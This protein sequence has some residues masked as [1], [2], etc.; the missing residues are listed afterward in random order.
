L[1][2]MEHF[3][4]LK[5][6]TCNLKPILKPKTHNLKPAFTLIEIMVVMAIMA[7]LLG[8][9]V[10]QFRKGE[11]RQDL[12]TAADDIKAAW[13]EMQARALAGS[14]TPADTMVDLGGGLP[15]IAYG[16][17]P[18]TG[19]G[20]LLYG[21]Q[22]D[23]NIPAFYR[24]R[25]DEPIPTEEQPSLLPGEGVLGQPFVMLGCADTIYSASEYCSVPVSEYSP[26]LPPNTYI[27]KE[28]IKIAPST[29]SPT[30]P[31]AFFNFLFDAVSDPFVFH[32]GINWDRC[33]TGLWPNHDVFYYNGDIIDPSPNK[34]MARFLYLGVQAPQ[35]TYTINGYQ[36]CSVVRFA[37]RSNLDTALSEASRAKLWLQFD[38]RTGRIS[39]ANEESELPDRP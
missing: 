36:G 12:R 39:T 26:V 17:K 21:T 2:Y 4:F 3:V 33:Q 18:T 31:Y 34:I 25:P 9:S 1:F 15:E 28:T 13:A 23:P 24:Y 38:M 35:P 29:T 5:P 30:T 27:D 7:L 20:L 32:P 14:P 16:N 11:A 8:I 6:T 37:L 10:Y 19:Y 22:R